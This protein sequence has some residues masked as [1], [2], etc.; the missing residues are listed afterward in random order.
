MSSDR[1][2]LTAAYPVKEA[3]V[4]AAIN[5]SIGLIPSLCVYSLTVLVGIVAAG[6]LVVD[7]DLITLI[8]GVGAATAVLGLIFNTHNPPGGLYCLWETQRWCFCDT[9][10]NRIS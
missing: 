2:A 1:I 9:A 6:T 8:G 5:I 7:T 3:I 4:I 10:T